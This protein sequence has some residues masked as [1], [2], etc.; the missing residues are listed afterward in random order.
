MK[1]RF[2][3]SPTGFIHLGNARTALF[4]VLLAGNKQGCFLLRMEDTDEERS[5][6][7]FAEALQTDLNWLGIYWQEGPEVGGEQAPYWQSQRSAI[8]NHY[9]EELIK[10]KQ[11]YPCFCSEE[12]LALSRK[13]QRARGLAPR[14]AGTCR[15]LTQA[16]IEK[17]LAAGLIPSLRFRIPDNTIIEFDDLVKGKQKYHSSDIGD[18]IIKRSNDGASFMFCNAIDDALM[19]ITHVLRGEDHL[20]NTP[21][22][23]MIFQALSLSHPQYAHISLILGADGAPLSKRN[24][25]RSIKELREMGFLPL[26][27]VNYLAR[28]GHYYEDNSFMDLKRLAQLFQESSLSKS[29]ARYDESQLIYWQ[30]LAVQMLTEADFWHWVGPTIQQIVPK[31][32]QRE[33]FMGMRANFTFPSEAEHWAR[34]F[35]EKVSFEKELQV[36]KEAGKEFFEIAENAFKNGINPQEVYSLLS[37]QLNVKG[38]Q[39]FMPL[40]VALTGEKHGPEMAVIYSLLN[41]EEIC[42]RLRK[43]GEI[44]LCH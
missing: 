40:R 27:V 43:A 18:F 10:N 19:G 33:F 4:N 13:L 37:N 1:T 17:K 41:K 29:P 25:S 34:I 35:F 5:K 36:L 11:A 8:Y 23:V 28:L 31:N 2:A 6:L 21:R 24:G 30:K 22:Q 15:S 39:L 20:T 26:A 44:E 42:S 9:Y 12:Q 38:K 3:P 14:Y 16:E 32:L 7:E